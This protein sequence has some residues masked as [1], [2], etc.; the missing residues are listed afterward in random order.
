VTNL[1]LKE[2]EEEEN[3]QTTT[4]IKTEFQGKYSFSRLRFNNLTKLFHA[5][6]RMT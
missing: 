6:L 5:T 4:L 3:K 1:S 2:E